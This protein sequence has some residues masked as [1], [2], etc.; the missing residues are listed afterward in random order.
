MDIKFLLYFVVP[1]SLGIVI[2]LA[3]AILLFVDTRKKSKVAEVNIEDWLTTG[4]KITSAQLGEKQS[5]DSYEPMIEYIY[6]V[7]DTEHH[8]NHIFAGENI[9]TKKEAAQEVL[10]KHPVNMY[11]P[12]RYD[13]QTPSDSALE[14]RPHSMNSI[15]LAGWVLSGFGVLSCCFT[16]FMTLVIFGAAQ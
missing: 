8:G 2:T 3:G 10:D 6:T 9:R 16:A 12:V 14:A 13:P 4:G 7:N 5:D 11:V 15:A 1:L